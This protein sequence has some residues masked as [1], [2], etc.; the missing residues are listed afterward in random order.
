MVGRG[1]V[2]GNDLI[3]GDEV[4]LGDIFFGDQAI[5]VLETGLPGGV[6]TVAFVLWFAGGSANIAEGVGLCGDAFGA[7]VA[8][9][10][11]EGEC[12]GGIDVIMDTVVVEGL[13]FASSGRVVVSEY[14]IDEFSIKRGLAGNGIDFQGWEGGH[15][16][17]FWRERYRLEARKHKD[18]KG[19]SENQQGA[20]AD[21]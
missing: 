11:E 14:C 18:E 15:G 1:G 17:S 9:F 8:L 21:T 7:E 6:G 3:D 5:P 19:A 4:P 2:D 10:E 12:V 13:A 20:E 16:C